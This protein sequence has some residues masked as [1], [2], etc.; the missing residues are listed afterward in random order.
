MWAIT[1]GINAIEGFWE[2][3]IK[4]IECLI[5]DSKN[6]EVSKQGCN[7]IQ[8]EGKWKDVKQ[9]CQIYSQAMRDLINKE[10]LSLE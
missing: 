7:C 5:K 6:R 10:A 9:E 2:G 3:Q 4:R 1:I 8:I